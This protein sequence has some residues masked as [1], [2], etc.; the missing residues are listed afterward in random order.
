MQMQLKEC[1]STIFKFSHDRL[2]ISTMLTVWRKIAKQE[3]QVSKNMS[4]ETTVTLQ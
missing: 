3:Y 1:K 4:Q 2:Q